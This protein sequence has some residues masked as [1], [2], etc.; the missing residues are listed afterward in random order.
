[1]GAENVVVLFTDIVGSTELSM[2]LSPDVADEVRRAHFS[3]LRQA[4][5]ETDG[6][7]VK[8]LGDPIISASRA[9]T[10]TAVC[11]R[12]AVVAPWSAA[13]SAVWVARVTPALNR[14]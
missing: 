7:E 2:S 10:I 5:A 1:M 9:P 6:A 13:A 11:A 8:N 4:I 14:D 12:D 3:T